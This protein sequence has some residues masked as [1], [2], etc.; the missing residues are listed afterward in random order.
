M[1]FNELIVEPMFFVV[2][3]ILSIFL[4][5]FAN[6]ITPKL[7][8]LLSKYSSK[9]R[10]VQSKKKETFSIKVKVAS[11]DENKVINIKLDAAYL[12]IR[13]LL[14]MIV[15]FFVF[16]T[17]P[18]F[19]DSFTIIILFISF[20]LVTYS[21]STLNNAQKTYNIAL[22]ATERAEKIKEIKYLVQDAFNPYDDYEHDFTDPEDEM[23]TEH[24]N[25]WDEENI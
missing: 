2:S 19:I 4:S 15:S 22:L 16:M 1:S 21:I 8:A 9:I 25:A 3:T 13:S 10:H 20:L 12:L 11:N 7:S 17:I 14:I 18:Y 5:V 23:F 24:L 6:I